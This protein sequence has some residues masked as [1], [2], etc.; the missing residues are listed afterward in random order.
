MK[1]ARGLLSHSSVS[2][3]QASS[4]VWAGKVSRTPGLHVGPV[5]NSCSPT[6]DG[7]AWFPVEQPARSIKTLAHSLFSS[8]LYA[9]HASEKS[10]QP[11]SY[12]ARR[13]ESGPA[14]PSW[15]PRQCAHPPLGGRAT[16]ERSTGGILPR[17][18]TN[19]LVSSVSIESSTPSSH[20]RAVAN[21]ILRFYPRGKQILGWQW[22]RSTAV[23]PLCL[24]AT[25]TGP[26]TTMAARLLPAR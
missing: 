12:L 2:A 3:H 10:Y 23:P 18:C 19:E 15:G 6:F 26:S 22:W 13:W 7:R 8:V 5:I 4:W 25:T 1:L 9:P 21:E 17:A 14:S 24:A 16:V 20:P 11:M